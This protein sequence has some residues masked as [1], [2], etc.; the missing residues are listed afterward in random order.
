[1]VEVPATTLVAP[2]SF[3][4]ERSAEGGGSTRVS[5]ESSSLAALV[6]FA[7]VTT[8][9]STVS[10]PDAVGF[11]TTSKD[12]F[13]PAARSPTVHTIRPSAGGA[14]SRSAETKVAPAGTTTV[15]T[16]EEAS[17]GPSFVTVT[18]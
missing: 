7:D 4:S 2:S 14:Q 13:A 16:T 1:V 11:K 15:A 3:V 10:V 12:V 9:V 6:S 18:V 8:E 5:S 17:E